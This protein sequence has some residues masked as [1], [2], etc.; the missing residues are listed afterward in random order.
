MTYEVPDMTGWS[1]TE[2]AIFYEKNAEHF[3]EIFSG[4]TATFVFDPDTTLTDR[5][6]I[7][8]SLREARTY[9]AKQRWLRT[10]TEE[11]AKTLAPVR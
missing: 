1:D 7:L 4:E 2:R 10:H 11:R 5:D 6:G 9:D 3:D 8:M